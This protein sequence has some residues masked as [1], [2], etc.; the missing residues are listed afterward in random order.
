MIA[1][2]P[3][4]WATETIHA[5]PPHSVNCESVSTSAVTRPTNTPRRS[6]DWTAIESWWMCANARTRSC[7]SALLGGPC[8]AGASPRARRGTRRRPARSRRRSARTR[9]PAGSRPGTRGRRSAARRSARAARRRPR[10]SDTATVKRDP[11]PELGAHP[12]AL[13]QHAPR[14]AQVRRDRELVAR[15]GAARRPGRRPRSS[16]APLVRVDHRGVAGLARHQVVV[17]PAG[18][19][20]S[21]LEVQDPVGE[22]DRREPVRDDDERRVR[23]RRGARPGSRPRSSGRPRWSRRPGSAAA[24][25][26]RSARASA[27][28]C[29]SPP[30][31]V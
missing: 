6:W 13:D 4:I 25:A 2:A 24:A 19:Q 31:S 1:S 23:A 29:R 3:T 20:A 27:T 11:A 9:S 22:P 7:A 16:L 14:A 12:D 30:D 21:V 17:R 18:A 15:L 26:G 28:R 8:R 5:I 10:A